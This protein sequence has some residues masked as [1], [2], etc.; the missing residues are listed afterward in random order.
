MVKMRGSLLTAKKDQKLEIEIAKAKAAEQQA[1][2]DRQRKIPLFFV[3]PHGPSFQKIIAKYKGDNKVRVFEYLDSKDPVPQI[4]KESLRNEGGI[5]FCHASKMNDVVKIVTML[6]LLADP[7]KVGMI[8]F[9][10]TLE[11]KEQR[12][13]QLIL[14]ERL[15]NY[16][17]AEIIEEPI[18]DKAM[19]LKIHRHVSAVV[20][21]AVRQANWS[22]VPALTLESDCW[23]LRGGGVKRVNDRWVIRLQGPGPYS[24]HWAR[25][26]DLKSS[27]PDEESDEGDKKKRRSSDEEEYWSWVPNDPENDPFV[28]EAGGWFFKG[29]MPRTEGER[30]IFVARQPLL[31]FFYEGELYGAKVST[32][33]D[34]EDVYVAEDSPIALNQL[35]QLISTWDKNLVSGKNQNANQ[36]GEDYYDEKKKAFVGKNQPKE[37][38]GGPRSVEDEINAAMRDASAWAEDD[39]TKKK[40][41]K[42]GRKPKHKPEEGEE[43]DV[44]YVMQALQVDGEE[45]PE[46]TQEAGEG[47][48]LNFEES[49]EAPASGEDYQDAAEES[50]GA[51]DYTEEAEEESPELQ[52]EEG[53]EEQTEEDVGFTQGSPLS[54][55]H[56]GRG[57]PAVHLPKKK[58]KRPPPTAEEADKALGFASDE[59]M[60]TAA[61]EAAEETE[62]AA[63]EDAMQALGGEIAPAEGEEETEEGSEASEASE[64][65]APVDPDQEDPPKLG[66]NIEGPSA[67]EGGTPATPALNP[68][69]M[70]FLIAELM[71]KRRYTTFDMG[72]QFCSYLGAA[73]GK[74]RAEIW[75]LRETGWVVVGT[76][77]GK[78]GILQ[79]HLKELKLGV[80][81]VDKDVL[82]STAQSGRDVIGAIIL[83]GKDVSQMNHEFFWKVSRCV[84]GLIVD[85]RTSMPE[86][87]PQPG[88]AA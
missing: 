59:Y 30:W 8:R 53:S 10:L 67:F 51:E 42:A 82:I 84:Y 50:A 76:S 19:L 31:G 28:K 12:Q 2:A 43:G 54:A 5:I 44:D 86:M 49:A 11:L 46:I 14:K 58:K 75:C 29:L 34:S 6:K 83:K 25:V 35:A 65:A 81:L 15:S 88:K 41:K 52:A 27:Q 13:N 33:T 87:Q 80:N 71:A 23:I 48:E 24:G 22:R 26:K 47:Q 72:S 39:E 16:D 55:G 73:C 63:F 1:S 9:I 60:A 64:E 57:K 70:A 77:D 68:L 74:I 56:G 17:F 40:F 20:S 66:V 3:E 38:G 36:E 62:A 85:V 69:A 61:E 79:N 18:N 4:R 21:A 32:D 37:A 7:V 78:P 45:G